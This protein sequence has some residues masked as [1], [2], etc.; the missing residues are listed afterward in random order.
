MRVKCK[1]AVISSEMCFMPNPA[2]TN[3]TSAQPPLDRL[4]Y[5]RFGIRENPF[6]VTPNSRY[7]YQS[8]THSEARATLIVGIEC[9]VGFQALIAPPG[10]GKTT[11]LF[12]ILEEY[13]D[14]ARTAFLFQ[15]QGDSRDF[16]RY[17]ITELGGEPHESDLVRMQDTINQLLIRERRAG[18]RVLLIIDEAQNLDTPVLETLRLLSNFETPNEK[19]LQII[20]AGQPQLAQ[21]LA[22]PELANLYQ[23]IT[24][25]KTLI[26]FDLDDTKSYIEHRLKVAGYE[27]PPLFT[28][29]AI[30]SILERSGGVPREIN[31][32]CFNALLLATA[33]KT[34]HVDSEI[35]REIETDLD[36]NTILFHK[37]TAPYGIR[38]V[39][40]AKPPRVG[41][42]AVAA[43]TSSQETCKAAVRGVKAEPDDAS[44]MP[45][46][47]EG[48]DAVQ[49]GTIAARLIHKAL[50][51]YPAAALEAGIEG[52]V[53][54]QALVDKSGVVSDVRFISGP[55]ALVPA[56]IDA[57]SHWQ[58]RPASLNGEPFAWESQVMVKFRLR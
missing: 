4:L 41:D 55:L 19:L 20:L 36:L 12:N 6:G 33:V 32:L 47:I 27:G 29:A 30:R 14:V 31:T 40:P 8:R 2:L 35:L 43:A 25:R 7:L 5:E 57:V 15:I 24:I 1:E 52:S 26:P 21:R 13:N 34:K 58:Y 18:K 17:L 38:E 45:I 37:D 10:M 54:L 22:T 46:V 53:A 51:V 48:V 23:R 50:P 56:A 11:I 9:G 39:P 3:A 44:T 49:L 16:L 28:P 42:V